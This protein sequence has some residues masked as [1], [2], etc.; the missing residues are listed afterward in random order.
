M[1]R[2]QRKTHRQIDGIQADEIITGREQS[3]L[4]SLNI[5]A[6]V[7]ASR[8]AQGL[9]EHIKD[10]EILTRVGRLLGSRLAPVRIELRRH[11]AIDATQLPVDRQRGDASRDLQ[12]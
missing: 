5:H 7:A 11:R 4:R 3:T 12:A 6:W 9:P 10:P 8:E 2:R 1:A